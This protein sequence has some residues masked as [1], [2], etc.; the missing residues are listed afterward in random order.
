MTVDFHTHCFPDK[1]AI[2]AIPK[3]SYD[4]GGLEPYTD[5]TAEGLKE[6]MKREDVDIS[7]VMHI[8]TNPHQQTAVND[9]AASIHSDCLISFGS[10]HPDAEDALEELERIQSL[11]LK[12]VK[13]H[14]EY[15]HFYVDDPKMKPIYKK[16]SQLGLIT[17]FHAGFDYGFMPPYHGMPDSMAKALLWFDSPV[18]AA[19]W[20]GCSCGPEVLKHL[21]GLPIYFDTSF[22]YGKMPKGI[23]QE[24]VNRHGVDMLLF[25]SD[26]P[27]HS[28][29]RE[30][31]LL[32]S[33]GLSENER[34]KIE[35]EN[36]MKLLQI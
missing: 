7:V 15:Q 33:L 9:F 5:G 14:P 12:G 2:K 31:L 25:G 20:G 4:A 18:I 16:I 32:D 1:L 34:R 8:A 36:A 29:N 24:I 28:P 23:A 35:S 13:L 22:G 3:L 26:S 30:R 21:C 17:L 19:H 6:S 11:G 27:W 10:V